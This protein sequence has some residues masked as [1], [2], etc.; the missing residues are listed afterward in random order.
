MTRIA[1]RIFMY[2]ML[3]GFL[4]AS[5]VRNQ[6][7]FRRL[8]RDNRQLSLAASALEE[9]AQAAATSQAAL[10]RERDALAAQLGAATNAS[11]LLA[12]ANGSF[13][14]LQ[15]E[16][17]RAEIARL[18]EDN[19]R[20]DTQLVALRA[21]LQGLHALKLKTDT[22]LQDL[23]S[24]CAAASNDVVRLR[25]ADSDKSARLATR[26]QEL[27]NT[28]SELNTAKTKVAELA[29]AREEADKTL[30]A[31]Q[32]KSGAD[33]AELAALRGRLAETP[34]KKGP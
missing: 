18:S 23:Q 26:E 9:K 31:L 8:Q 16:K 15:H 32:A 7:T 28:R 10:R 22:A 1:F 27:A 14:S 24:A 13:Q 5:L 19:V 21:Q 17:L 12:A 33:Q 6:Q 20:Q 11:S 3:A 2:V 29:S 4:I 30:Q 25:A 34:A